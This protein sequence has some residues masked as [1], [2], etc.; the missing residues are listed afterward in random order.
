[1]KKIYK[2]LILVLTIMFFST[3][4]YAKDWSYEFEPYALISSIDGEAGVG[5][6]SG[7]DVAVDFDAI[8]ETLE[9]AFMGHFEAHHKSGWGASL[10]YGFM[11]LGESIS[12]P[13][14]GV[15]DVDVHQGVLEALALY[16][17]GQIGRASCRERV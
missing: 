1:M 3:A 13:L 15:T 4:S 5:R 14:G 17:V 2:N 11:N 16:R 12:G 9:F 8:L 7:A 6:V 10:D